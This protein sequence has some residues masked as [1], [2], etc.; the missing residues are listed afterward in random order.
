MVTTCLTSLP[1]QVVPAPLL[2]KLQ[3][4][5]GGDEQLLQEARLQ[6]VVQVRP[7]APCR[8]PPCVQV[9]GL[10]SGDTTHYNPLRARRPKPP[11]GQGAGR[12]WAEEQVKLTGKLWITFETRI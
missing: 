11:G 8:R 3:G 6:V 10:L 4:W 7:L 12:E 2:E 1:L 5:L 9:T